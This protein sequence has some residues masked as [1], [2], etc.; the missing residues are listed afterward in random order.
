MEKTEV[1]PEK[2]AAFEAAKSS[3]TADMVAPE[4][5]RWKDIDEAGFQRTPTGDFVS[6]EADIENGR[7]EMVH[8]HWLVRLEPGTNKILGKVCKEEAEVIGAGQE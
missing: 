2:P 4:K 8:E 3:L 1:D 7:G 5:A 6:L